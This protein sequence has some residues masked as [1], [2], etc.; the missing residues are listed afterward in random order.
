MH[1]STQNNSGGG[2]YLALVT[3]RGE[4]IDI[5]ISKKKAESLSEMGIEFIS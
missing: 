4:K 2:T 5:L 1:L 3:E